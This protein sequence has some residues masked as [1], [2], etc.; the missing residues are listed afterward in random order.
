L[1]EWT[2]MQTD[3]MKKARAGRMNA[4]MGLPISKDRRIKPGVSLLFRD[5]DPKA[6]G[7]VFA[8][9]QSHFDQNRFA[10]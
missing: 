7:T 3:F 1:V 2:K 9:T 10:I 4:L 5:L 6:V 8:T